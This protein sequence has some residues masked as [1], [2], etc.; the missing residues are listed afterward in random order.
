ME[1]NNRDPKTKQKHHGIKPVLKLNEETER[2]PIEEPVWKPIEKPARKFNLEPVKIPSEGPVKYPVT[3]TVKTINAKPLGNTVR[4][5]SEELVGEPFYKPVRTKSELQVEER[6]EKPARKRNKKPLRILSEESVRIFSEE[7]H[8]SKVKTGESSRSQN[9]FPGSIENPGM[10][11]VKAAV[12]YFEKIGAVNRGKPREQIHMTDPGKQKN[13]LKAANRST[14]SRENRLD[15]G[16]IR[17]QINPVEFIER[18]MF[19]DLD[20]SNI[21]SKETCRVKV[22]QDNPARCKN[23]PDLLDG[24]KDTLCTRG[25]GE[26]RGTEERL[27]KRAFLQTT[28]RNRGTEKEHNRKPDEAVGLTTVE[29]DCK[30]SERFHLSKLHMIEGKE[31]V[32]NDIARLEAKSERLEVNPEIFDEDMKRNSTLDDFY[33]LCSSVEI[34]LENFLETR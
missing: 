7:L 20:S 3:N 13:I 17:Q 8:Q 33:L 4:K 5:P 6:S 23:Q 14:G 34:S 26:E 12:E 21:H 16:L 29:K 9:R 2:K 32:D 28:P 24:L 30:E 18:E 10:T 19:G 25:S 27:E 11:R 31:R 1:Q 15:V 22:G